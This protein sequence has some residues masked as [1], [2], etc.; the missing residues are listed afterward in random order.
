MYK[1]PAPAASKDYDAHLTAFK[2]S[3]FDS[4]YA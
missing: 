2:K 3:G 1:V 4:M